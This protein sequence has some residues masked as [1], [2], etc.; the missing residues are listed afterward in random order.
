MLAL[1]ARGV[2]DPDAPWPPPALSVHV[3]RL[4]LPEA[5]ERYAAGQLAAHGL[6]GLRLDGAVAA[7]I[8]LAKGGLQRVAARTDALDLYDPTHD[9]AV[10]G[11]HGG[12]D[13]APHG[14]RPPQPLGWRQA[15][16]AGVAL[17]DGATQ[18]QAV[19]GDLHQRGSW[20][21]ALPAGHATL[22][23][24]VLRL[25]PLEQAALSS[26]FALVDAGAE[27]AD[28]AVALA[29]VRAEGHLALGRQADRMALAADARFDGGEVLAGAF[30]VKLPDTPVQARLA[31]HIEGDTLQVEQLAWD[32]PGTLRLD[33]T[34]TL[35]LAPEPHVTALR[36]AAAD[37][38]VGPA[39]ARYAQSWLATRGF[40]DLAGSGRLAAQ[41]TLDEG[42]LQRLALQ[43][44][45]VDL[46]DPQ[47]RFAFEG[48]A[49]RLDWSATSTA[50]ATIGWDAADVL[51][52][53]LGPVHARFTSG[54]GVLALADPID[55][56]VLGG[57]LRLERLAVQPR[58]AAGDRVNAAFAVAGIEMAQLSELLGWPRFGG[59]L[60]GG[61]P[62]VVLAGDTIELRGGLDLYVFDGHL[63]VSGLRLERPFG[64]APALAA[65]VHFEN[66]DLTQ[67]TSAFSFGAMSGRLDGT[68]GGV[69]LVDWQPVAFDAWLRTRGGGRM[70]Y[71]AV[72]D[73]ASVG[74]GGGLSG[75]LQ[76]MALQLFDTFGY[77]RLGVRCR[78]RDEV[79]LMGGIEP[80]P[81]TGSEPA[82]AGY[83]IVEGSG[84]PR[85]S[86]IGHHRRV[87][88]PTLV[89]RL[90]EA[91]QGAGPVIE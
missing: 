22:H 55:I 50:P 59:N 45:D 27:G 62:E 2:I 74:G 47:G 37:V 72:N 29:G 6:D 75:G 26:T 78:L 63:G 44:D 60:S 64:V 65:N 42:G 24:T 38:Q 76:T 31:A 43:A 61:I 5:L 48:V 81:P 12:I 4:Q 87:D 90:Q 80:V 70:S 84:L 53:P 56:G 25:L 36:L 20:D 66:L 89:Q 11:L 79:C 51:H 30:Y 67:V 7:D 52:L 19:E 41:V 83:T 35:A 85:I 10:E 34:A 88:W 71:N 3:D 69:R 23:G 54:T 73:I 49:A 8:V 82:N 28:G 17:G 1:E 86:I 9:V 57:H 33:G 14:T 39:L 77:R 32:D 21:I 58:A 15:R 91:T 46:R 13:W 16:M 68:L 40:G 18:W